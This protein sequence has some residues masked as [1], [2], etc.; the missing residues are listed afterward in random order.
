MKT[1]DTYYDFETTPFGLCG[2]TEMPTKEPSTVLNEST[3]ADKPSGAASASS[4]GMGYRC[5]DTSL[6]DKGY[7]IS[8]D[9]C[10]LFENCF[11]PQIKV[12]N[13]SQHYFYS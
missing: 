9:K 2:A 7:V 1:G 11:N 3:N 13:K 6:A 8:A 4:D 10:D 5:V 12:R